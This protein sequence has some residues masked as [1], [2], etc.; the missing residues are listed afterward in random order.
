MEDSQFWTTWTKA[1]L[2]G[3]KKSVSLHHQTKRNTAMFTLFIL[4]LCFWIVYLTFQIG[5]T[6]IGFIF[7]L[8][9]VGEFLSDLLDE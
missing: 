5:I 3:Q 2:W 8:F 6:M 9:G 1:E 4:G 7:S